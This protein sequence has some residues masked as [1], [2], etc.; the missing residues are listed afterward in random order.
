MDGNAI[1][2]ALITIKHIGTKA[3]DAIIAARKQG[4]PFRSL[5]DFCER[6][7]TRIAN[8]RTIESL[9]LSGAFDSLEGCRAPL[10]ANLEKII[11][12]GK[13]VKS[14][15]DRGQLRLF[16]FD[17]TIPLEGTTEYEP[18]ARLA[19]EKALVGYYLSGHPVQEYRDIIRIYATADTETLSDYHNDAEVD[20]IGM[21]THFE[22]LITLKGNSMALF[23]LED[24]KGVVRVDVLPS[25]YR[26]ARTLCEGQI[27]WMRGIVKNSV[28]GT[29]RY[30]DGRS[31]MEKPVI[32]AREVMDIKQFLSGREALST[33]L[34]ESASRI[35]T[36]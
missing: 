15:R 5:Q 10:I 4:G 2:F 20:I 3:I 36:V 26:K 16:P 18:F 31:E 25:L 11:K 34:C 7:D 28:K 1:N 13:L 6:V 8:K 30:S 12:L 9:I 23:T 24:L 29:H 27:V 35:A 17:I 21:I 14:E 32:Q 33:D 22:E 19:M